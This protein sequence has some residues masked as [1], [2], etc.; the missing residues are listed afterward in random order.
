MNVDGT[1]TGAVVAPLVW[2]PA[3]TA[4]EVRMEIADKAERRHWDWAG[5]CWCG[6]R[7]HAGESL[8]LVAPPWYP[9]RWATDAGS[10]VVS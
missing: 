2:Q 5:D 3:L 6:E 1:R 10:A 9:S 8:T 7:H 4:A